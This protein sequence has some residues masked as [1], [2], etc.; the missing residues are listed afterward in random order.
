MKKRLLTV[1]L[2]LI[3]LCIAACMTNAAPLWESDTT[4]T[5]TEGVQL[6]KLDRFYQNTW[7]KIRVLYVDLTN[8]NLSLRVLTASE[9]TSA[10]ETTLSMAKRSGAVA[11]INGDFFNMTSGPTNMLGMVV[12]DGVLV[13]SPARE[14]GLANFALLNDNTVVMDYFSFDALL[15]SPQGY[16]CALY[17]INKRPSTG[18]AITLL[19]TKFSK[20]TP[21][22]LNDIAMTEMVVVDGKV[23]EIRVGEGPVQI[24]EDGYVLATNSDINGFLLHNYQVGDEVELVYTVTPEIE[25]IREATGGGTLL[26]KDGKIAE[27][28]NEIKGYAQRAAVGIDARGETL[29]LVTVD[30]RLAECEGMN[31]TELARLLLELGCD[32]AL[33]LDGGG[34]TTMVTRD[35][36]SG[37]LTVQNTLAGSMRA[38]STAIGIFE[39]APAG[40][41]KGIEARVS[42]PA[43]ACGEAVEIEYVLYDQHYNNVNGKAEQVKITADRPAKIS[44]NSVA[45]LEGGT[46]EI[47]LSYGNVKEKVSFTAV[48]D[49]VDIYLS[50]QSK[51]MEQ[52]SSYTFALR[53]TDAFGNSVSIPKELVRWSVDTDAFSVAD[54]TVKALQAGHG[55]LCAEFAGMKAYAAIA[56]EEEILYNKPVD[57]GKMHP[58]YGDGNGYELYISG[59]GYEETTLLKRLLNQI[60]TAQLAKAKDGAYRLGSY[61]GGDENVQAIQGFTKSSINNTLLLTVSN[62]K[63]GIKKTDARQWPL[64]IEAVRGAKE[65]SIVV[66]MQN[67][68]YGL[69]ENEKRVFDS[70]LAEAVE[71]GK[72]VYLVYE[73]SETDYAM[74]QG[75]TYLVC[76]ALKNAHTQT[77]YTDRA[78]FATVKLTLTLHGVKFEFIEE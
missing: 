28:T 29:M 52:G 31:Q 65:D 33:N 1:L 66:L 77:F 37:A 10:R 35:R 13:S 51:K 5:V 43:V 11:A 44:G 48:E 24:P 19:T 57:V 30:G 27:F 3:F 42:A 58:D 26:V 64:L 70:L 7:D 38:V 73:G 75:V 49:Y 34:S 6:R 25:K 36:F 15:T 46:Y 40:K 54:G 18:G 59:S 69:E 45:P 56:T 9:G 67:S 12:Q 55:N 16:T 53:G 62:A 76:G 32:T 60:R 23:K 17:A 74:E 50:V 21:G 63:G 4:Q 8:K 61:A 39:A 2:V 47:T 72:K 68:V 71:R 22:N 41:V 20:M 78:R 14:D